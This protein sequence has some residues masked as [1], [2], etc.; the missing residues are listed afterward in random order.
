MLAMPVLLDDASTVISRP[1]GSSK[2]LASA[3]RLVA[4][5]VLPPV[6]G[7]PVFL[8]LRL[9]GDGGRHVHRLGLK[10][11]PY[12]PFA[13][14]DAVFGPEPQLVGGFRGSGPVRALLEHR[15]QAACFRGHRVKSRRGVPFAVGGARRRTWWASRLPG[16]S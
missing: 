10:G 3:T 5:L 7:D 1:S 13:G 4:G 6:L 2:M 12:G 14:P 15:L 8:V 16:R 11:L 9:V